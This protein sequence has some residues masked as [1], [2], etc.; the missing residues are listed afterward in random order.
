[1]REKNTVREE[2]GCGTQFIAE[3]NS[4]KEA[5]YVPGKKGPAVGPSC[6]TFSVPRR[7]DST[8]KSKAVTEARSLVFAPLG[9][10]DGAKQPAEP[11]AS[12]S[13]ERLPD[14]DFLRASVVP[15][16]TPDPTSLP[17]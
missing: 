15:S 16:R 3:R 14:S 9:R 17:R 10:R 4:F 2:A 6:K 8:K 11:A 7:G 12:L 5:A 1:M 13:F